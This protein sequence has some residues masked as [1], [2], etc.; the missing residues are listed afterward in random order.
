[1][2][3]MV[4]TSQ[5]K[6]TVTLTSVLRYLLSL[7]TSLSHGSR[8]EA[9]SSPQPPQE[10][11][12]GTSDEDTTSKEETT[13]SPSHLGS[14]C[15]YN[16][17]ASQ[18]QHYYHFDGSTPT[19]PAWAHELRAYLNISQFENIDLLDFA[20]D[21]EQSLTKDIMAQQT[22]AGRRQHQ[23][24]QHNVY[25]KHVKTSRTSLRNLQELIGDRMPTSTTTTINSDLNAQQQQQQYD[26]TTTAVRRAGGLL[27]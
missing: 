1:M 17:G 20:H 11:R 14:Q 7:F 8:A 19:F 22:P 27:G 2:I 26:I 25:N 3:T 12:K 15:S 24:R 13:T 6:R 16:I 18:H 10:E 23:E 9:T 5:K 4:T 21:A